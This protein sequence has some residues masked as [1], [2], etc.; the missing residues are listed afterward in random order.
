MI[1]TLDESYIKNSDPSILEKLKNC[2]D[3]TDAQA[4]AAQALLLSGKTQ[5]GYVKLVSLF[6]VFPCVSRF[7]SQPSA[8]RYSSNFFFNNQSSINVD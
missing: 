8:F 1:C 6:I 5:Y 3:L 2:P 4:A 7:I